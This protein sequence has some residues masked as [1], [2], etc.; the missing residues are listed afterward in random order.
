MMEK[1]AAPYN[2]AYLYFL[3]PLGFVLSVILYLTSAHR[4]GGRKLPPI[5]PGA[6]PILGHIKLMKSPSHQ[7]LMRLAQQHGPIFTLRLGSQLTVVVTSASLVEECFTKNDIA[8]ANRP[9]FIMGKHM[10]YEN[11]SITQ[12]SY[13]DH[14]R[15][16]RRISAVEILSNQRINGFQPIRLQEVH[17]L[18]AN[19]SGGEVGRRRRVEMKSAFNQLAFDVMTRV[20]SGK[21]YYGGG[22]DDM[23][24]TQFTD[25][26]KK[27][28]EYGGAT[29]P[30][31]FVP[32][33]RWL[34][35]G[36]Y[37]KE[38]MELAGKTDK[39]FQGLIDEQRRTKESTNSVIERLLKLQESDQENYSDQ[40]IKNL[41]LVMVLGG[42]ETNAVTLEWAMSCLL[43]NPDK[44][45]KARDEIDKQIGQE[46]LLDES[47]I[48]NL[49]YLQNIISETYRMYP[50]SPLLV[51][52]FS[53]EDCVVGG[54]LVPANT[55]VL[56]NAY[57]IHRDP[58]LWEDPMSFKPE[59]HAAG[60][61]K[62]GA[63]ILTFGMGRRVCPGVGMANRLVAFTLGTLIQCFEWERVGEEKVDMTEGKGITMPKVK[64][65][66]ALC[67]ARPVVKN[68]V[69]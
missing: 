23:E 48:P 32:L 21:R 28:A 9:G 62:D 20:V 67:V 3:L 13:C 30:V 60:A 52:H 4:R 47:D 25:I 41:V 53:S 19:L 26:M 39:F 69:S 6:L 12:I 63:K 59:R 57:A 1:V 31:D 49:P 35:R 45:A 8:L 17:R 38:A 16:L 46:R 36:K 54:Y 24:A 43:N 29:N 34:D 61:G 14:W 11:T 66:E 64:P 44:L 27:V 68:I 15:H 7:T 65:L 55:M 51:P 22:G 37:E 42:T 40:I 50:A 5:V 56:V 58:T 2:S 10:E 18:I 33:L